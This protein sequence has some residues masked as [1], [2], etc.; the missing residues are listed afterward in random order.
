MQFV[1]QVR[2]SL[3][4]VL[5]EAGLP[6]KQNG[7]DPSGTAILYCGDVDQYLER[8]PALAGRGWASHVSCVDLIVKGSDVAVVSV[9][10]EG[11]EL[12][13]LLRRAGVP[14]HAAEVE[15]ALAEQPSTALPTIRRALLSLYR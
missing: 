13:D 4:S 6:W 2:A 14:T 8:F 9:T 3:D 10:V 1:Q 11:E 12:G 7:P 5:D 15:A